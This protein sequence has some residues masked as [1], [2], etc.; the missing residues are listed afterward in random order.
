MGGGGLSKPSKPSLPSPP[1]KYLIPIALQKIRK[2]PYPIPIHPNSH[3]TPPHSTPPLPL[4]PHPRIN[5]PR[6]TQPPRHAPPAQPGRIPPRVRVRAIRTR[7]QARR[8]ERVGV[9]V[10][11]RGRG[12]HVREVV[13]D[14]AVVA[15][16][17]R[18]RGRQPAVRLVQAD[19][20]AAF[21]GG[22]AAAGAVGWGVRGRGGGGEGVQGGVFGGWV[23]G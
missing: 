6:Q 21:E 1:R 8:V 16:R 13:L 23:A 12:P 11:I 15:G 14:G 2:T 7:R 4:P 9:V 19:A 20:V 22:G 3:P 18:G 5:P 10:E 17:G